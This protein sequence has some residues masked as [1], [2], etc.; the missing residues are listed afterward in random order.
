MYLAS[1]WNNTHQ[2]YWRLALC[3]VEGK[4]IKEEKLAKRDLCNAACMRFGV[5]RLTKRRAWANSSHCFI[6]CD[7]CPGHPGNISAAVLMYGCPL[8][9]ICMLF[10]S[11]RSAHRLILSIL[12][13]HKKK[14][15]FHTYDPSAVWWTD[16]RTAWW[17]RPRWFDLK[18]IAGS[19]GG[20]HREPAAWLLCCNVP[21][22]RL[23]KADCRL[24]LAYRDEI[25]QPC[26]TV[27]H[28]FRDATLFRGYITGKA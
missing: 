5:R 27:L 10:K 20:R 8:H 1:L 16:G 28:Y 6:K 9:V 13:R 2:L 7:P 26:I 22:D 17:G 18:K 19:N 3:K 14:K 12:S 4:E 23:H 21:A 11:H 25:F 15:S 24:A